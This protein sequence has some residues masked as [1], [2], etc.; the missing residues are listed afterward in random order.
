[1]RLAHDLVAGL[2]ASFWSMAA[3]LIAVP[4]LLHYLGVEAYGLIGFGTALQSFLMLLDLGLSPTISR[5]VAR[6]TV[7]GD[8]A[9]ARNLLRSLAWIYWSVAAAIIVLLA[10]LAG[11]LANNWLNAST[12][13]ASTLNNAILLMALQIGFRWPAGLYIGALTGAHRIVTANG[14][15]AVYYT[16]ANLGAVAVVAWWSPTIEAYFI[17][18]VATGLA[19]TMALQIAA[20]RS[21]GGGAGA[22]F[23]VDELR[24]I[25]RFAAGMSGVALASVIM[26][27]LDKI[28]LSRLL[29]LDA[30]AHYMIAVLAVSIL[31]RVLGP[32][33]NAIYPRFSALVVKGE[34]E[35]LSLVYRTASNVFGIFWFPGVML[36]AICAQPLL[37]LWTGDPRIADEAAALLSLLAIGTGL[38]GTMFFPYALQLAYG[39]IRLTLKIHLLLLAVQLPLLLTLAITF[40]ALGGA[41]AWVT[42]YFLYVAIATPM[43][44]RRMLRDVGVAWIATDLGRPFLVSAA[45]GGAGFLLMPMLSGNPIL[46]LL[47]G[48]ALAALAVL[49]SAALS[50]H[51]LARIKAV[52]AG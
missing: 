1:M 47:A 34:E 13:S 4:F 43:T 29:S 23:K 45:L 22:R 3:A 44:H 36:L 25:W 35:E 15:G 49:T 40:G 28:I 46:Q 8:M 31:Y 17:W 33:F 38:H 18:Q 10:S 26:T 32:V 52:L 50:P 30:F 16:F 24:L 5:Q 51:K 19:Y 21:L 20:W 27:Q 14:I 41:M 42:L 2:A 39:E 9:G 6:A 7:H 11:W 48:A 12:I 37:L